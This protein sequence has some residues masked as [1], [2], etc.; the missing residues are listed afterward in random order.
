MS[1]PTVVRISSGAAAIWSAVQVAF[2]AVAFSSVPPSPSAGLMSARGDTLYVASFAILFFGLAA[3]L[4]PWH[5]I[6]KLPPWPYGQGATGAL[7]LFGLPYLAWPW[8][9]P[10]YFRGL[11]PGLGTKSSLT[12]PQRAPVRR[13]THLLPPVVRQQTIPFGDID[14]IQ[15][16]YIRHEH[17]DGGET[18]F[19]YRLS[20]SAPAMVVRLKLRGVPTSISIFDATA[21][22]PRWQWPS[23]T[24]PAPGWS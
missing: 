2:L 22:Y 15:G 10:A 19:H 17:D 1:W 21:R 20:A 6:A 18:R 23:R 12:S 5:R 4:N 8:R 9:Y 24:N 11:G 13:D 16:E 14:R 7:V 3:W